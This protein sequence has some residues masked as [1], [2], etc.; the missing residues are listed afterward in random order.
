MDKMIAQILCG[1]CP[2]YWFA[3]VMKRN[4]KIKKKG[5]TTNVLVSLCQKLNINHYGT[6]RTVTN[7]DLD[8]DD[9]GGGDHDVDGYGSDDGE[10][11]DGDD[12][13]GEDLDGDDHDGDYQPVA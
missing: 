13:D 7:Y 1:L 9:H 10:N 6:T 4:R 11:L 3:C 8:G 12:H 2:R 5:K